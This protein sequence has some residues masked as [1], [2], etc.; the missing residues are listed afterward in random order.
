MGKWKHDLIKYDRFYHT[1]K[2]YGEEMAQFGERSWRRPVWRDDIGSD[3]TTPIPRVARETMAE[4][5]RNTNE[6]NMAAGSKKRGKWFER[7]L[8]RPYFRVVSSYS[9]CIKYQETTPR[10]S[11]NSFTPFSL[12]TSTQINLLGAEVRNEV[13]LNW[14]QRTYNFT[15]KVQMIIKTTLRIWQVSSPK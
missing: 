8:E 14:E 13:N 10:S 9:E 4:V 7:I 5:P 3:Q 12:L 11:E 1:L 6:V 15:L 2:K